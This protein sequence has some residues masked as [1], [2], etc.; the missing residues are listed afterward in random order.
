MSLAYFIVVDHEDP[1][2]DTFVDGKVL[3]RNIDAVNTVAAGLGQKSFDDYLSQD[4][5]EF[6]L[7]AAE[8]AWFEAAEGIAWITALKDH[9]AAHPETVQDAAGVI[10]DLDAFRRVLEEAERRKI[11]WHLELDF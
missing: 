5:T 1:G 4:L 9:V 6:G 8:P 10:E 3:T 2:F 7:E 11:R